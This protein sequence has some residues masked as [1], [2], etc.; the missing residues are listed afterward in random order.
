V[1]VTVSVALAAAAVLAALIL[2][3][4]WPPGASV[5]CEGEAVTPEGIP[6]TAML[7]CELNPFKPVTPTVTEAEDPCTT[8]TLVGCI[9]SVKSGVGGGA[10]E[11]PPPPPDP[12]QLVSIRAA[13]AKV[14]MV[15]SGSAN[16]M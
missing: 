3:A 7:V 15:E 4:C 12:P 9:V 14:P 16:P 11:V 13:I 6:V 5:N 8:V 1:A 10:L 2:T